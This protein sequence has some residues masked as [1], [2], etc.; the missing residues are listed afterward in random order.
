[1]K[2]TTEQATKGARVPCINWYIRPHVKGVVL[3]E[4][5]RF[6]QVHERAFVIRAELVQADGP[7]P[8][9]SALDA[10]EPREDLGE[11]VMNTHLA[12]LPEGG[13]E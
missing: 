10:A 2:T 4:H 7:D 11:A 3:G 13:A 5:E 1:M 8:L 12:D 9:L 6:V